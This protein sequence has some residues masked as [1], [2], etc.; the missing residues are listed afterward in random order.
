M[1]STLFSI[2]PK[3][4]NNKNYENLV[5]IANMVNSFEANMLKHNEFLSKY[6]NPP[7]P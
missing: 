1:D 7:Q 6:V 5:K 3:I 2:F 4:Q